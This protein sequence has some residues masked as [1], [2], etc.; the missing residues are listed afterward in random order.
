MKTIWLSVDY[1]WPDNKKFD[2]FSFGYISH[3]WNEAW[4]EQQKKIASVPYKQGKVSV[5]N[6]EEKPAPILTTKFKE[7]ESRGRI[8]SILKNEDISRPK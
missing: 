1:S 7:T 2:I 8:G 6:L 3:R 4:R 5:C